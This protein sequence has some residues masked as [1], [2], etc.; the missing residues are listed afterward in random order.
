MG[1][2]QAKRDSFGV[3]S[4]RR[5]VAAD[6]ERAFGLIVDLDA[7]SGFAPGRL[8][9]AAAGQGDGGQSGRRIVLHGPGGVSRTVETEVLVV[10]GGRSLTGR[11][12]TGTSTDATVR[13][14]VVPAGGGTEV[15]LTVDFGR[16]SPSDRLLLK[17]GGRQWLKATLDLVLDGFVSELDGRNVVDQ[18]MSSGR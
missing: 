4:S 5:H 11:A 14:E 1:R 15:A 7:D 6:T 12:V 16:V 10:R 9:V 3:V 8:D 18:A 13:W 17:L 2:S